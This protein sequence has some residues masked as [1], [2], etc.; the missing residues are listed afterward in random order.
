MSE[1]RRRCLNIAIV[2]LLAF[3]WLAQVAHCQIGLISG[4]EVLACASDANSEAKLIPAAVEHAKPSS[5][6][7]PRPRKRTASPRP[8]LNPSPGQRRR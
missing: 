4:F 5:H 3:L 1:M 6:V 2:S 8:S 7:R